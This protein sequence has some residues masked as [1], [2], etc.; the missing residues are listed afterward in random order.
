MNKSTFDKINYHRRR[1]NLKPY[2]TFADCI[3]NDGHAKY[4]AWIKIQEE[5]DV[6]YEFNEK[7]KRQHKKQAKCINDIKPLIEYYR[8][9]NREKLRKRR[10]K[11]WQNKS[12]RPC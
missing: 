4:L 6:L 8:E 12:H 9:K 7:Q 1:H 2:G 3:A 10:A 11:T 5:L